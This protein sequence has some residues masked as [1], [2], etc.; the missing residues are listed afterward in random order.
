[1]TGLQMLS[2]AMRHHGKGEN[3]CE[4]HCSHSTKAQEGVISTRATDLL[5]MLE[6]AEIA[7]LG[8]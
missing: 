3:P 4:T 7:A 5:A 2:R 1:M 8:Q 6:N